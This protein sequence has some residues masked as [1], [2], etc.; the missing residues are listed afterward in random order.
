MND[1][2]ATSSQLR[3]AVDLPRPDVPE[4][5]DVLVLGM[6]GSGMAARVGALAA[7]R[8]RVSVHQSY[9]IPPWAI[10]ARPLCIAVSYSG[11]TE[12]VLS[13]VAA[14]LEAGLTVA[15]VSTGGPLEESLGDAAAIVH[16]PGG[17][18]PR[19]ALAFQAGAVIRI[20]EAAGVLA[21]A[22]GNLTDAADQI[23]ALLGGGSGAGA[24]LGRDI[25]AALVDKITL[26]YGGTGPAA[27]AAARWKAQIN[28]NA[29]MPAFASE[30]PEANHNELEGWGAR[31]DMW[32]GAV[33]MVALDDPGGHRRLRERLS[34]SVELAGKHVSVAGTVIAQ[35]ESPLE[36]FFTLASVGD[37]A[38]V[39]L[40]A[41]VGVDPTPVALLEE[42][43]VRLRED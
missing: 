16:V 15:G 18:Q 9:G 12:E 34:L 42:F 7:D 41:L 35:G 10:D 4:S 17:L 36:R 33:V 31:P 11:S 30:L 25:A 3:W 19:A 43:K 29:K 40:A 32:R 8:G 2:Y 39:E 26:V 28:E 24:A 27:L 1:V 21:G 13:G 20:L 5:A 23:D 6:G 37:V 14:A 22:Q 38:S